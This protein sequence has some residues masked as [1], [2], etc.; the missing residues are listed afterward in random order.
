MDVVPDAD[1][2]LSLASTLD[3]CLLFF[4][5][6]DLVLGNSVGKASKK[7]SLCGRL[8]VVDGECHISLFVVEG[9]VASHWELLTYVE[10]LRIVF[11]FSLLVFGEAVLDGNWECVVVIE[12][13]SL[14]AEIR[15][16]HGAV[17]SCSSS[18]NFY[19]VQSTIQF[20]LFEEHLC[21]VDE[22]WSSCRVS[23]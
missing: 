7:S 4:T 10:E 13:E 9:E 18:D 11:W 1:G 17:Q 22:N 19:S 8:V 16:Q 3:I 21:L 5:L 15:G 23:N 12:L 2:Q 14:H 20:C 6:C